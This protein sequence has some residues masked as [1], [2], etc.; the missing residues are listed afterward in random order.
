MAPIWRQAISWSNDDKN[1]YC[2]ES[3]L[4]HC[5]WVNFEQSAHASAFSK[6]QILHVYSLFAFPGCQANIMSADA[7]S[8]PAVIILNVSALL[9]NTYIWDLET[10]LLKHWLPKVHKWTQINELLNDLWNIKIDSCMRFW[11][12]GNEIIA[13]FQV[14]FSEKMY[15]SRTI[16]L[17]FKGRNT[18]HG[19]L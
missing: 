6:H 12:F 2:L 1:V 16:V 17:K 9:A 14:P 10:M 11:V 19:T 15:Y 8:A 4:D 18:A 5:L 3:T 13:T 7:L